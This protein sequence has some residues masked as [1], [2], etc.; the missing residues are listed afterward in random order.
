MKQLIK[1]SPQLTTIQLPEIKNWSLVGMQTKTIGKKYILSPI[2]NSGINIKVAFCDGTY[3]W[4]SGE[5]AEEIL[6][7]VLNDERC[8]IFVFENIRELAEWLAE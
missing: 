5:T 3:H 8:E 4:C 6:K 2:V 7:Y 1:E